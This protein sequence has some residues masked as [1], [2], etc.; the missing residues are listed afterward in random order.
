MRVTV[1]GGVITSEITD[2][3]VWD[4]SGKVLSYKSGSTTYYLRAQSSNS[5]WG[6]FS[7]PTLTLSTSQSTTVSLSS[8]KLKMG[9]YYLRYSSS[10]ISLNRSGTTAG[11]FAETAK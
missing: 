4:Y 5:W 1:S 2:D 7:T 11:L 10:A 3:L 8:N 9:S 6:W